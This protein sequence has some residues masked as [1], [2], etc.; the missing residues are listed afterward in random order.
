MIPCVLGG[1]KRFLQA[2]TAEDAEGRRGKTE[3]EAV[4]LSPAFKVFL[5][6]TLCPRR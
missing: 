5:C 2:L 4:G 3:V 1:N 6:V